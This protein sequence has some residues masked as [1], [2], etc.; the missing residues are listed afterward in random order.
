M[1]GRVAAAGRFSVFH[2]A[3]IPYPMFPLHLDADA[4]PRG[5]VGV[6]HSDAVMQPGPRDGRGSTNGAP[7]AWLMIVLATVRRRVPKKRTNYCGHGMLAGYGPA[8]G[9]KAQAKGDTSPDQTRR[10]RACMQVNRERRQAWAEQSKL[11]LDRHGAI[12]NHLPWRE[13]LG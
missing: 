7:T 12:S 4:C 1:K 2:G 9:M 11:N 5:Q 13:G 6:G 10:R 3:A 8:V